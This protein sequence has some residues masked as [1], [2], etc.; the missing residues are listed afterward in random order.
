[1][2]GVANRSRGEG[3]ATVLLLGNYRPTLAV[4]RSLAQ[5]G[6]RVVVGLGQGEGCTEYSRAVAESWKHPDL[7]Q[8]GAAFLA[9]LRSFLHSR[10]DIAIV[11]PI[12][13]EFVRLLAQPHARLPSRVTLAS[14]PAE[15][16]RVCTDK[17]AMLRLAQTQRLHQLPFREA[18]G[19]RELPAVAQKI[20]FPLVIRPLNEVTRIGHKKALIVRDRDELSRLMPR[21]AHG[22]IHLLLQ[23]QA[24]GERQDVI[25]AAAAGRILRSMQVRYIRTDSPDGTGLCV[26]G[27]IQDLDG[28]LLEQ[29]QALVAALGYTGVGCAQFVVKAGGE[30]VCFLELNPR[31][32]AIH[33]V[34]EE[35]GMNL[36][37]LAIG[38]AAG[39]LPA[40]LDRPFT[41]RSGRQYAWTYGEL[42]GI[43]SALRHREVGASQAALGLLRCLSTA[44]TADFHLTWRRDD[45]LPTAALFLRQIGIGVPRRGGERP[46]KPR[47][48]YRGA[49]GWLNI[50]RLAKEALQW[51]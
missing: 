50:R 41:Y 3:Q 19:L 20:G 9:A 38:L 48:S 2:S 31:I 43:K 15:V 1:M 34:A 49:S 4:A 44:L 24:A 23:R 27:E 22:D 21:F 17:L 13:E 40:E 25:F 32:S 37:S 26:H 8:S 10:P 18:R 6:Y 39:G 51:R 33:R 7:S 29:S 11:F 28:R 35:S 14:P 5:G 16:V 36:S 30:D 12:A 46:R 45:P 47:P 42:R